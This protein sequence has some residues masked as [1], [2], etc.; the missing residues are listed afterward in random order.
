MNNQK[1]KAPS[2]LAGLTLEQ[3]RELLETLQKKE[4]LKKENVLE[5]FQPHL[6]QQAFLSAPERLRAMFS[7][8]G[9]GK[10]TALAI[11]LIYTHLK[12]HPYRDVSKVR[13]S[14]FVIPGFDKVED[15]WNEIKR[16]CP[17]SQ[18]P[19]PNKMGTSTVKRLE[20]PNGTYTTFYSH[21]QD[22]AKLEGSNIDALF[23][24]E[25]P[26]RSLW[27]AA[28]RGLRN[29]PDYFVVLAGTPISEP[30]L[31]EEVYQPWAMK[32]DKNIFIVQG[33]TY[34]NPHLSKV[35]IK[36]FESRLTDDEKRTRIH[37][38]FQHLQGRVF[39]EFSRQTSVFNY[40]KWPEGWPV[41]AAVDPHPRKPNTVV[42][43]GVTAD[44]QMVVINELSLEGTPE[45][46][47][48]AMMRLEKENAYNVVCRRIDNSGSGTD[49]SRDS[50]ISRL[51]KWS[52]EKNYNVRCSPMRKAEKDV[53]ESIHKIKRLLKDQKLR[54]LDNCILTISDM[55]LYAWQD[56]RHPE[57]AGVLEKP[58]KIHDDMI[59][60]LRYII[61]SNPVHSPTLSVISTLQ[62]RNPYNKSLR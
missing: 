42:Y 41:Y 5:T 10:T 37:G 14:W 51:D 8:N 30:W 2:A 23:C 49:W 59:D 36:D 46:L 24:D 58:R 55:E 16:W 33:S 19:K 15:Y 29:N 7:G 25:P 35:W 32:K 27:I 56:Y 47:A 62:D 53:A 13:H 22:S 43:L 34:D 18:L 39:K 48:E 40:Q 38:E 44:D 17:P 57:V 6:G 52:R 21:D 4:L 50:F 61:M 20:W 60:P 3:K 1:N 11:D 45:D 26:P 9:F 31:Y 28:F 54:F 12:R